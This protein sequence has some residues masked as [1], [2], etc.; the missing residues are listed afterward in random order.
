MLVAYENLNDWMTNNSDKT[1]PNWIQKEGYKL[2][3][4]LGIFCFAKIDIEKNNANL[5]INRKYALLFFSN[6]KLAT[7]A[8]RDLKRG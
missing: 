1:N 4:K 7:T 6:T 3:S 5:L 8:K 2:V